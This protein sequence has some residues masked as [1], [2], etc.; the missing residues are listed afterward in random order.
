M[1]PHTRKF[2]L[3]PVFKKLGPTARSKSAA[4]MVMAMLIARRTRTMML[5]YDSSETRGR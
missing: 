1:L 3:E 5:R 2:V 4:V